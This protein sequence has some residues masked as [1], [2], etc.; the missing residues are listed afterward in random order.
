MTLQGPHQVAKKSTIITPDSL[1][2]ASKSALLHSREDETL[3]FCAVLIGWVARERLVA[4]DE[5]D[6]RGEVV[7]TGRHVGGVLAGVLCGVVEVGCAVG[8][9]VCGLGSGGGEGS[10]E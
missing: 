5:A 7:D 10:G 3:V 1:R 9:S 2:A 4:R 6:L 8:E